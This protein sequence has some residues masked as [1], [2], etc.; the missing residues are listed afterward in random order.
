MIKGW[1]HTTLIEYPGEIASIVFLGG[2]NMRCPMCHNGDLVLSPASFPDIPEDTVLEFLEKRTGKITGIVISGGEPCLSSGLIPFLHRLKSLNIKVKLDSNGYRP[3]ILEIIFGQNLIDFFAMDV[4]AP[5][6]KYALLSG[7]SPLDITRIETSIQLIRESGL[8]YEFRTTVVPG[9]ISVEDIHAIGQWL[10]G[11]ERYV[12]QQFRPQNC[13][14]PQLNL[15][16]PYPTKVLEEM[17]AVAA[18][19]FGEVLLRGA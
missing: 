9:L 19:Y 1:V 6:E 2:C 12:L 5:P 15:L 16:S 11:T 13:L 7:I 4:K 18:N 14:D 3:D 10:D 8:P 17:K